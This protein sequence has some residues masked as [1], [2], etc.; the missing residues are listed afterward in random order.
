MSTACSSGSGSTA[1]VGGEPETIVDI[2]Y[3]LAAG[4]LVTQGI[5]RAFPDGFSSHCGQQS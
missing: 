4:S 1:S 3:A 2:A 5:A